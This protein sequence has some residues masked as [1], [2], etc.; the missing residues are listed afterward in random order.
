M[1]VVRFRLL[2]ARARQY[3]QVAH[4]HAWLWDAAH[5]VVGIGIQ[6]RN[7]PSARLARLGP[8]SEP[9]S[10]AHTIY[11]KGHGMT[12]ALTESLIAIT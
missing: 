9:V 3:H 8:T 12:Q 4:N 5:E 6:S 2:V 7:A 10:L 1:S 11:A